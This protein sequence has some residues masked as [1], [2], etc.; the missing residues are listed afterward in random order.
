[1]GRKKIATGVI[2][3]FIISL[4]NTNAFAQ[5]LIFEKWPGKLTSH[6]DFGPNR[7][8]FFHEFA[9]LSLS[10]PVDQPTVIQTNQLLT[11]TFSLGFRYKLKITQPIALV[12]E[13]GINL[14]FFNIGQQ[15]GKNF[16]DTLIHQ[17]QSVRNTGL[18]GGIL[19]RVRLGQ[20]G[21]YLGRYIDAGVIAEKS[22]ASQLITKD[23]IETNGNSLLTTHK[24]TRSD[25]GGVNSFSYK[26]M[27][28][29]GFDRISLMASYR[30][31]RLLESSWEHDLP[32]LSIGLEISPFRY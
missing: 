23:N 28:R 3:L 4:I 6:P 12:T 13:A 31:S 7:K 14:N 8:H 11:G 1:M 25:I 9:S 2:F 30:L 5:D 17:F 22:I 10:F 29:F 26:A 24:T 15:T 19:V 21:D 32:A 27:V 16:P 20:R 18:F